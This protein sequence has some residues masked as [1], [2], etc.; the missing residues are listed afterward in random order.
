MP[1]GGTEQVTST[2]ARYGKVCVEATIPMSVDTCP[3]VSF[4]STLSPHFMQFYSQFLVAYSSVFENGAQIIGVTRDLERDRLIDDLR[5]D[6]G[7]E[8]RLDGECCIP[9]S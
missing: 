4:G 2:G 1:E 5:F 8:R 6:C 7:E 3:E 9:A